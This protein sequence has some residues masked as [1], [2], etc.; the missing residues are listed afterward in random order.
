[1]GL[2]DIH[3]IFNGGNFREKISSL[4]ILAPEPLGEGRPDLQYFFLGDAE[5]LQ[6]KTTH[7]G[8]KN[9]Q[10]QDLKKQEGGGER[11][12]NISE[13]I[14][15]LLGTKDQRLSETLFLHV[16]CYTIC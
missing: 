4:G 10:L 5:T 3:Q 8:R 9:S 6:Q 11:F 12:S 15:V 2:V 1:M 14:Q 7:K 13:Q 16:W